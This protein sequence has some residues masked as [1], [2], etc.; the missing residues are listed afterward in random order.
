MPHYAERMRSPADKQRSA[1]AGPQPR[2]S[3][4]QRSAL[5][6][7][8]QLKAAQAAA[9]APATPSRS[10]LP[11]QLKAG[12][13]T[14]SGIA[15]D[16]VR[17]HRNSTEPAKLEALAYAKGSD[18]H[19]GPGQERHLPHEAWHVV[20]Q[21]Q[22][23]V[24]A[25][26]QLKGVALNEDSGLE[27][28]ADAMGARALAADAETSTAGTGRGSA[29]PTQAVVQRMTV[30][31]D[32]VASAMTDAAKTKHVVAPNDQ[33]AAAKNNE[34]STT[35]VTSAS[36]ITGKADLHDHD[37][38][39]TKS[40]YKLAYKYVKVSVYSKTNVNEQGTGKDVTRTVNDESKVCE[41]GVKKPRTN[42]LWV[43]HFKAT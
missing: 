3:G 38:P 20:Q 43:D 19:L 17:V 30:K 2:R 14:L 25:T 39:Y 6:H 12:V 1:S 42:L 11:A 5:W 15:M 10:A 26:A 7:V 28:E 33:A 35:F 21:K 36:A 29:S 13:E 32:F 37:F 22:G 4:P 16:D 8:L 40:D 34:G 24:Q 18:I 41:I 9:P 31:G 23:R 27:R